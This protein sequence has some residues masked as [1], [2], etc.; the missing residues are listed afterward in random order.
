MASILLSNELRKIQGTRFSHR[1]RVRGNLAGIERGPI[2]SEEEG[3]WFP[4]G[5]NVLKKVI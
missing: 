2:K 1:Q 3:D 5:L 4:W